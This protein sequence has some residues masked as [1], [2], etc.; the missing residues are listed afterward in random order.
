MLTAV[1]TLIDAGNLAGADRLLRDALRQDPEHPEAHALMA[2]VLHRQNRHWE[3]IREADAAIG[4]SPGAEAFRFKA[5]ALVGTRRPELRAAAIEA[6]EAAV[7]S[8][9]QD[10]RCAVVLG[11][12]LE[13]ARR[14]EPAEA[15]FRRAVELAP[16]S[17]GVRADLGLYLLRRNK[18]KAAERV[19]AELGPDGAAAQ[20]LL[21][22]GYIAVRRHRGRQAADYAKWILSQNATDAGALRLLTQAKVATNPFLFPWW[23]FA[24]FMQMFPEPSRRIVHIALMLTPC[25]VC[26]FAGYVAGIGYSLLWVYIFNGYMIIAG[27]LFKRAV[28]KEAPNVR[29]RPQ[30]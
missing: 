22:K 29:L 30:F 26:A 12:A 21:L 15:A 17:D 24:L 25:V 9:P 7:A 5:L 11:V 4:L 19:A 18:L 10:S 27:F 8:A 6:A 1:R 2:L 13:N 20:A 23:R 16:G 14:F 28:K 3:A